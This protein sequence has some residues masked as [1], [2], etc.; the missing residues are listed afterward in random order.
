MFVEP[1]SPNGQAPWFFSMEP[2]S[3]LSQYFLSGLLPDS[4]KV[5]IMSLSWILA[6][7]A[8]FFRGK[9]EDAFH[10]GRSKEFFFSLGL[11]AQ[12]CGSRK[13]SHSHMGP[14]SPNSRGGVPSLYFRLVAAPSHPSSGTHWSTGYRLQLSLPV[15]LGS[16]FKKRR[17]GILGALRRSWKPV[18]RNIERRRILPLQSHLPHSASG[19]WHDLVKFHPF[20]HRGIRN[21]P[22][23]QGSWRGKLGIL[24]PGE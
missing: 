9:L 2:F 16:E 19:L 7:F 14:G 13:G 6:L 12:P 3:F 4:Y 24:S 10:G 20:F 5:P 23:H 11:E 18:S 17:P 21:L 22:V 8:F 15:F 1:V